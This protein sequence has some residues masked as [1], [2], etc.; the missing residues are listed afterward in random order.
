LRND[1]IKVPQVKVSLVFLV[2]L[3]IKRKKRR[4]NVILCRIFNRRFNIEILL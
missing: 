1:E 2:K 4:S 3:K